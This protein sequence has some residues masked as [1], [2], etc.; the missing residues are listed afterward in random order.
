MQGECA[1]HR[2]SDHPSPVYCKKEEN[3]TPQIRSLLITDTSER[4]LSKQK[5]CKM[6]CVKQLEEPNQGSKEERWPFGEAVVCSGC[7]PVLAPNQNRP[8][9]YF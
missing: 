2:E 9:V 1:L 6:A 5:S 3:L 8:V 4:S 7:A